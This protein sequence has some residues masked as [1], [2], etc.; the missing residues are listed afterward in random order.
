MTR[1]IKKPL[2]LKCL[3]KAYC[4]KKLKKNYLELYNDEFGS[5][6]GIKN[7]IK[8]F[9]ITIFLIP[10]ILSYT[11]WFITIKNKKVLLEE[12]DLDH[13]GYPTEK[14]LKIIEIMK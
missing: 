6:N 14:E 2:L 12:F 7:K 10:C 8:F 3:L 13:I 5:T 11:I 4:S 9:F 1:T